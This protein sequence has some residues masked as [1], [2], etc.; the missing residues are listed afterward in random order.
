MGPGNTT[1]STTSKIL[2]LLFISSFQAYSQDQS[3]VVQEEYVLPADFEKQE[4]IWL[5][6]S[7]RSFY[8]GESVE[9]AI[10]ASIKE[11]SP[12][13]K[14]R[15]VVSEEDQI[16][17]LN[18]VFQEENIDLNNVELIY[19][20]NKWFALRDIGPA[21]L[22]NSKGEIVVGD[23]SWNN[24]GFPT[25]AEKVIETEQVDRDLADHL[26]FPTIKSL[27]VSEG[28]AREVNGK[29]TLILVEEVDLKRNI[30][31]TT[32]DIENEYKRMLGV[33]KVIWLKKGLLEDEKI[34]YGLLPDHVIPIGSGGHIDLFCRFADPN[35]IL[36]AEISEEER[37][38][39]SISWINYHRME[40]N[41]EI[42]KNATDQDGN[43]FN[44]LRVPA[45]NVLIQE[46]EITEED[47]YLLKHLPESKAG[48]NIKYALAASYLNFIVANG[49]VLTANYWKEGRDPAILEK[50]LKV[51]EILQIAFP[52]RQIVMIDVESYNHDR[53]GLHCSS[54]QQPALK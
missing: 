34:N 11:L 31:W 44:I 29:G 1:Y 10:L 37:D 8:G 26:G 6:Y 40:E 53:G 25:L 2:S 49:I 28:G 38:S 17:H 3:P 22:K 18:N 36:L 23:F 41:Y 16:D 48:D 39:N 32:Q 52:D 4:Y 45:A 51:K 19:Y 42:L 43:P 5:S 21:F 27:L 24:L 15:L 35:T 20:P 30:G 47:H 9:P 50:D 33:S 54:Q 12:Y 46:Y 13:V 14:I 7:N